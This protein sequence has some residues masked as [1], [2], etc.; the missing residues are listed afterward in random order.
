[1]DNS[2]IGESITERPYVPASHHVN[3]LKVRRRIIQTQEQLEAHKDKKYP[4]IFDAH[5]H[6][7]NY[8]QQGVSV[9]AFLNMMDNVGLAK[10]VLFGLPLRQT[11]L[12]DEQ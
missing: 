8:R 9:A 12:F 11:V 3:A 10:A 5:F 6:V 1:S 2:A 4:Y 7:E